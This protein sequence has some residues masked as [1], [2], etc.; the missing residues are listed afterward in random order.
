M[1]RDTEEDCPLGSKK[2][3]TTHSVVKITVVRAAPRCPVFETGDVF[4]VRQ[5]ILDTEVSTIRN[6]CFHT[7]ASLHDVFARIRKSEVGTSETFFCRDNKMVKFTVERLADERAT[8]GRGPVPDPE[9]FQI[10]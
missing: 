5:H 10:V 6:F 1:N 2:I 4:Y 7:L 9:P 3:H 8:I